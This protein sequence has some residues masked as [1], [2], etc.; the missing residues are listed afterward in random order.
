MKICFKVF[1]LWVTL[2][3]PLLASNDVTK[4]CEL[5]QCQGESCGCQL[6]KQGWKV[7][8]SCPGHAWSYLLQKGS[9]V[10]KCTGIS[11][12]GGPTESPCVAYQGDVAQFKKCSSGSP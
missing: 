5:V 2:A 9:E 4:R 7:M 11:S 12:R 1:L 10:K 8:A 6:I 3:H